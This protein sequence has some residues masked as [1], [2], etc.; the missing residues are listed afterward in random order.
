MTAY[1]TLPATTLAS[2]AVRAPENPDDHHRF[3]SKKKIYLSQA[4]QGLLDVPRVPPGTNSNE[5]PR[6]NHGSL[7]QHATRGYNNIKRMSCWKPRC[8][9]YIC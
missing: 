1:P 7:T 9:M 6:Q 4:L 3:S 5:Y 2:L 8:Y